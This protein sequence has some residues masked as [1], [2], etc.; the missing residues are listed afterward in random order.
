M[1]E[2]SALPRVFACPPGADFPRHLVS[3][4]VERLSGHPPEALARVEI[5]VNT[6]R[7]QRRMV[8][9]FDEGPSLLLP[10]IRLVTDLVLDPVGSDLPP[11]V[12]DLQRRL[13]LSRLIRQ[14]LDAQ[15]DLAPRAALFDLADS[16]AMLLAEMQDEGVTPAAIG[17]LRVTDSSGYW[18][19]SLVFLNAIARY[20]DTS[21]NE[22]PDAA[23]RLR[24]VVERK[25]RHWKTQPPHHPVIVAGSTGSRG[26][27]SMLMQAVAR[28]PQGAIVL[29][30]F[31]FD[32]PN[33]VWDKLVDPVTCEDHPQFRFARLLRS[34]AASHTDVALWDRKAV[35]PAPAR[36]KLVSLALRPAPVT[37]QWMTEGPSFSDVRAATDDITLIEAPS[38]RIEAVAIAAILRKAAEDRKTAALVTPDRSLTRQ[39]TAALDRWGIEPDVSVGDPLPQTAVGRLLRHVADQFGQKMTA[40]KML[41]LLKHPMVN[42]DDTVR[43]QHLLWTF[44]LELSLRRNGPPY[45]TGKDIHTWSARRQPDD[46]R[47]VWAAWLAGILDELP[48]MRLRP[49][50]EHLTDHLK[51]AHR[52]VEGPSGM[53][54][55]TLWATENGRIAKRLFDEF[56]AVADHAGDLT[57]A[58]YAQLVLKVLKLGE[59]R[60]PV[61]PHPGI[62]IWG[63]LEARVQGADLIILGGLNDG[64]WPEL[65]GADPW[66]NRQLRAEAGLLL[67]ERRIGLSAHDFQQAIA[68][69]EV[70]L[71]RS[72]RSDEAE[73]VASRWLNRLGNL[74]QG[75]SPEGKA[76]NQAIQDRGKVWLNLVEQL[77][78]PTE[79]VPPEPRPSPRPPVEARPRTLSVTA[80]ARLI[81]D[82]YA[83]YAESILRLRPL[84]PLH[85]VA[86]APMRGT[87]LH[88]VMERFVSGLDLNGGLA[89]AHAQLMQIAEEI[90]QAEAPWPAARVLW[91]SKLARVTD[92]FLADEVV[93]QQR[94]R[95]VLL[96]K[97]GELH[98]P[99]IDFTLKAKVDRI[100]RTV[101]GAFIIYD[102]KTGAPPSKKQL[103][104]FDK[105]LMLE[106]VMAEAGGFPS[107]GAAGVA[108]VAHIGLGAKPV[109]DPVALEPGQTSAVRDQ[110]IALIGAYLQ[111][112]RGY[113][114]RRAMAEL[115]H[116]GDFDHLA[117][118]GEWDESQGPVEIEV[119]S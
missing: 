2:S 88:N 8:E 110:F 3:G 63:T 111:H 61:R 13:D 12:S 30:G 54:S 100:D 104:H 4:L 27:T 107:I 23:G 67:P 97:Q 90:L 25:I 10:R 45:P 114:S 7:M 89:A 26:T 36:N 96:E 57:P 73:T 18:Q 94:A 87:V 40:E 71:T 105:Q 55:G 46:G 47:D 14:L 75:V 19:R 85:Q 20:F 106:A 53:D 98:F 108:E 70:V 115:R 5:Y 17:N 83:I 112:E 119:G 72:I 69:K 9:L 64:T 78:Q 21:S 34:L 28:L 65:P 48:G 1:F 84:D 109:F 11:P 32:L 81:R 68:A 82:P 118:Y 60:D 74:M 62:M 50:S 58:D 113:T 117:R 6:R 56:A 103:E 99:E 31:D 42:S 38:L 49:A 93:R 15:P 41:V 102:Y 24:Q 37:D 51:I 44:D 77:E 79:K 52:L 86:D 116:S 92:S 66:L 39:V 33:T 29:P 91:K 95:V 22:P 101:D 16:L 35:A 43:G 80:I 76:A 59:A